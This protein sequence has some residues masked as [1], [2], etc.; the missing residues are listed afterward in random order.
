M[1]IREF[2]E[3]VGKVFGIKSGVKVA[4]VRKLVGSGDFIVTFI[5]KATPSQ[6][7]KLLSILFDGQQ[8]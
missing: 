8:P 3:A 4:E 1:E 6:V 7:T 5:I 2:N